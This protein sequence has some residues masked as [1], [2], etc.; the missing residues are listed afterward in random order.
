MGFRKLHAISL[1]WCSLILL[2][3]EENVHGM[4]KVL[5]E[6]IDPTEISLK[7]RRRKCKKKPFLWIKYKIKR[8]P[9]STDILPWFC[10]WLATPEFSTWRYRKRLWR[11]ATHLPLLDSQVRSGFLSKTLWQP[12]VTRWER[13]PTCEKLYQKLWGISKS[14]GM[15]IMSSNEA[16]KPAWFSSHRA[17]S[18]AW[19]KTP[20]CAGYQSKTSGIIVE[21]IPCTEDT[22][23]HRYHNSFSIKID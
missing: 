14:G 5:E 1:V 22:E 13:N 17:C 8:Q 16:F 12:Q 7:E 9:S 23:K 11:F 19:R 15:F 10:L 4:H 18:H 2:P 3:T 20:A 21:T 6:S